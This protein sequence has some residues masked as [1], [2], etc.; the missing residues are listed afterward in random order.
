MAQLFL[1]HAAEE[2]EHR[3]VAYDVYQHIG[4][5]YVRRVAAMVPLAGLIPIG[6][7][8]LT[9]EV[10]RRNPAAEGSVE[11]AEPPA[12]RPPRRG[13][14]PRP[15]RVGA[16]PALRARPPPGEPARSLDL[17]LE[18]LATAPSVLGHRGPRSRRG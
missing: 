11:L 7:P 4:G 3:H 8:L 18:H 15:L 5:G 12:Q 6:W 10:M 13:V 16:P 1:W 9:S 17:A 2:I 14:L